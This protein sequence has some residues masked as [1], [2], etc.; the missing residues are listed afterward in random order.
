MVYILAAF[1]RQVSAVSMDTVCENI[2]Y[3]ICVFVWTE[4]STEKEYESLLMLAGLEKM[5]IQ[6]INEAHHLKKGT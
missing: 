3:S 4:P 6:V 1:K 5:M 2:L